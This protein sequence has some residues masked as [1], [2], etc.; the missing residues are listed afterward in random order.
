MANILIIGDP[1]FKVDNVLE[2]DLFIERITILAQNKEPDLII[3]LGDVL[4]DH[5]RLHTIPLN[6][7]Y[8]FINRMR[9][10]TKT[11]IIVGNHDLLNHPYG[12]LV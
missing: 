12:F 1:Q 9:N 4:H 6:K 7:A 5:E 2:V 10:I 8:E 11:Y 3:I